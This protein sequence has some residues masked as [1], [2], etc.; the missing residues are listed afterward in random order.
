LLCVCHSHIGLMRWIPWWFEGLVLPFN[1]RLMITLP[2]SFL[3]W[4]WNTAATGNI[5]HHNNQT[6]R[7]FCHYWKTKKNL[8]TALLLGLRESVN[9]KNTFLS[10]MSEFY[11]CSVKK[12]NVN[13]WDT[14]CNTLLDLALSTKVPH[15]NHHIFFDLCKIFQTLIYPMLYRAFHNVLHD[16]KHV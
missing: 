1:I 4:W 12:I 14:L 13:S 6:I 2:C 11:S 7:S 16:Y 3:I 5:T 10:E 15:S 9:L 8:S